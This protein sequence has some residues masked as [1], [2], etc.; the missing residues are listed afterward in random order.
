M[1]CVVDRASLDYRWK[2]S[3]GRN[4]LVPLTF[5]FVV[6]AGLGK[7]GTWACVDDVVVEVKRVRHREGGEISI[8]TS[9]PSVVEVFTVRSAAIIL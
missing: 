2:A 4:Y 1:E 3:Y 8:K 6:W 7:L 9:T 5:S